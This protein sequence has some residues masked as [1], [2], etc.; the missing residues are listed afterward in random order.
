MNMPVRPAERA[1]LDIIMAIIENA[2]IF[3]RERG[4]NQWQNGRPS[5]KLFERDIET[6]ACFV[7]TDGAVIA[8]VI[9]VFCADEPDYAVVYGG[10]WLTDG[11]P[12]AVFHRFAVDSEYRGKGISTNILS[13]AENYASKNGMKSLRGDT[14]RDNMAMRGLLGKCG[15][16]LCGVI[17]IDEPAPGDIER[18]CYEKV[19]ED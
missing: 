4:V 1:D 14:H 3:L 11:K 12:Y 9:S 10:K 15:Y 16:S 2:K 19:F 13:Y 8:G 5:R 18:L 17:H 6:G 7:Y